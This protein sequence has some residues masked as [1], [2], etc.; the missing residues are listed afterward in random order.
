MQVWIFRLLFLL[1]VGWFLQQMA[2]RYRLFA[3][4]KNNL[5]TDDFGQRL[6]TWILDVVFQRLS[7]IHISEPTRPY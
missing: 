5:R 2:V 7:L 1:F 3:R 4:A 6:Q